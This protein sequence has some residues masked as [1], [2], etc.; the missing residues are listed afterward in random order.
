VR[1]GY[2]KERNAAAAARRS[3]RSRWSR[4]RC[5]RELAPAIAPSLVIA[6]V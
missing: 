1:P 4:R 6:K 3:R 2:A 5:S